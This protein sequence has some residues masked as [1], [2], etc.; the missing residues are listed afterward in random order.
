VV[1][2][3]NV[4][5]SE[6]PDKLQV[7]GRG[8]RP[9][10]DVSGKLVFGFKSR[11]IIS[12]STVANNTSIHYPGGGLAV[13]GEGS[14]E[15]RNGTQVS[16][17]AAFNSSG[18]GAVLVG[19][20]T[21]RATY[22]AL[23]DANSV[24]SGY[25]GSTIAAF[26]KST[27]YL[28]RHGQLTRCSVGVYLGQATSC[29]AGEVPLSDMCICCQRHTFNFEAHATCESCPRNANCPGGSIVEPLSGYWQSEPTSAQMHRCPWSVD[30][31]N[32]TGPEQQCNKGF[33]GPLCGVCQRPK[34]GM[35][36]P[37]WCVECL[38][39]KGLQLGLYILVSFVS[40][41][42]VAYTVH[43][44]WRDNLEGTSGVKATDIIKALV[45]FVQYTVIIGAVAVPW[46]VLSVRRWFEA[47]GV[48]FGM[49]SSQTVSLDCWLYGY[50]I[51]SRLPIAY[52]RQ[53]VYFLAPVFVM[54]A[55]V[56][57]QWLVWAASR[58]VAPLIRRPRKAA[59]QQP[60]LSVV[61][62]LPVTLLVLTFYAYP[63]L[64]RASLS[65]FACLRIDKV[66]VIDGRQVVPGGPGATAPLSHEHGYWV[67]NITQECF[68][69]S[70]TKWALGMGVPAVAM[71]CVVVPVA[72]GLGLFLC[73][74]RADSESFR[75][76]FGF[77]YCNYRPERMWWE[78]V[79]AA[80]TVVLSLVSVFT[81]P[82]QRYFSVLALLAVFW[83]SAVLQNVFKPYAFQ[84]L[85]RMHMVLTSCLA[86]T[87]LG[88]LVM[89]AYDTE[90]ESQT[91]NNL[92]IAIAVLV[93]VVN[94]VVFA[95]CLWKLLPVLKKWCVSAYKFVK[96]RCVI[97]YKR[98]CCGLCRL[99]WGTQGIAG[100]RL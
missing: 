77:L 19:N 4:A 57:L 21:L 50:P 97:A 72:M 32:Y 68:A 28:P 66:T 10:E 9:I 37:L 98:G 16:H 89:F 85:H 45:L 34:Y 7:F 78:A 42:F 69:G 23:F 43:A 33:T 41:V 61:R 35:Q 71:W 75:E 46:P 52:Q 55:V 74:A 88:A 30:A 84:E 18:G 70:H 2:H 26:D 83:A 44:T 59:G 65:L 92:R 5:I 51:S 1:N 76:H 39:S 53:L 11:V 91:T 63:T 36:S 80:R 100:R 56:A 93:L 82:M 6:N 58:W 27:L 17:N 96:K 14:I 94:V 15:L 87:T 86:V 47:A 64:L 13:G 79:W 90:Q 81:F 95:W 24:G 54:L 25:V 38:Q 60:A 48:V 12:H 73:R 99:S 62:K 67:S 49:A 8:G 20:A 3:A 29:Q 31:C 22:G 40:V